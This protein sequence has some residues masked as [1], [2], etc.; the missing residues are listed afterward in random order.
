MLIQKTYR[1][2]EL[3]DIQQFQDLMER[4]YECTFFPSALLDTE[5]NV[6][7]AVGWQ[8]ICVCFHRKHPETLAKCRESDQEISRH[9]HEKVSNF[10]YK[11]ANGL[12]DVAMPVLIENQHVATFFFGQF[13]YDDDD[14]DVNFFRKQA[15]T[16]GFNEKEYLAAFEKIPTYSR[17]QVKKILHFYL[18][19]AEMMSNL[20]IEKLKH[21]QA[22]HNAALFQQFVEAAGQGFGMG[23]FDAD[24]V[25]TNSTLSKMLGNYSPEQ[26]VGKKFTDLY[27]PDVQ[28]YLIKE[29]MPIVM[30][31]GHWKG[32][33]SYTLPDGRRIETL[34]N[35]FILTDENKKPK[36]LADVITD[37][38]DYK[39]LER[40]L[41]QYQEELE[42]RVKDRT[43]E[44]E[45][46][47]RELQEFAYVASHD[48]REPLR[49]ISSF[50]GLFSKKYKGKYDDRA[51]RYI[52]YMI[53][54]A[55]RMQEMIEALLHFSRVGRIKIDPEPLDI[56]SIVEEIL[57]D[58]EITIK[59]SN[60]TFKIQKLPTISGNSQ[61]IHMLFQN[62]ISNALKFR[63]EQKP[64]I[65]LEAISEDIQWHFMVKDN[66]IGIEPE[67]KDTIFGVFQRLHT[68]DQY[69]GSGIGL[70]LCKKIVERHNGKIWVESDIGKGACFHFFLPKN[71][72]TIKV[73]S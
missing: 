10:S 28:E 19:L 8:D 52:H 39:V 23:T 21:R 69:P 36:Y 15:Q 29:V 59:E 51:D 27:S 5:G 26:L 14:I 55:N 61:M 62:L 17:D 48:L 56:N 38:T 68:H 64:F 3:V 66:G 70:A 71:D 43:Y 53:D 72:S 22:A 1:F 11:C 47:N 58:F 2:S 73:I 16:Y 6:L 45:M 67:F 37:V 60:A 65:R 54:A 50:A 18:G 13:F 63:C 42:K 7:I 12:N 44:L 41:K 24:I 30:K 40:N 25:Y 20:G 49:K 34:E 9:I 32:E 31:N 33:L 4:L 46:S 57:C 35:F